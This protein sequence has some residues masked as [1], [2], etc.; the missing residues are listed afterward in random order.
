MQISIGLKV[1]LV[2]EEY[3][4]S[5]ASGGRRQSHILRHKGFPPRWV[6]LEQPHLGTLQHKPQPVLVVPVRL[7]RTPAQRETEA[8]IHKPAYRPPIPVGCLD[9]GL[10]GRFMHRRLQLG[11][12]LPA[13]RGG[14]L[15]TAQMTTLWDN[16]PQTSW[17][18]GLWCE[19]P[20]P[21][22]GLPPS[23][24]IPRVKHG[25]GSGPA[26]IR[27]RRTCHLSL[28]RG[29]D[30]RYIRRRTS[31]SSICHCSNSGPISVFPNCN[32]RSDFARR[33][34]HPP[35]IPPNPNAGFTL[36]LV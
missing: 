35:P 6:C 10:P 13:Q 27:H 7:R 30:A 1:G 26:A 34:A 29:V 23:P 12:L 8:V 20:D 16:P 3:L 19:H 22:P 24:S 21:T 15:P 18:I 11:L 28:A 14:N 25:A 32:S 9:A 2:S 33:T 36:A 17:P 4:G 5:T 31:A